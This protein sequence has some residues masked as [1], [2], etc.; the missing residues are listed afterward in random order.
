M[1]RM[2]IKIVAIILISVIAAV[3]FFTFQA[4]EKALAIFEK[5]P[6]ILP[7]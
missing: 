7:Q 5:E 4:M 1:Q 3:G 2:D 6:L